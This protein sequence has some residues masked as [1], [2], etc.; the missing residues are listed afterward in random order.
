MANRLANIQV[1]IVDDERLML[2][3]V[4]EVL[5]KL[6][7]Q[8]ITVAGSGREAIQQI[9]RNH[10]DFIITDWRMGDMDGIDILHFVRESPQSPYL[11]IPV[12]LLTGNTEAKN[13]IEARDAGVT[14]YIIKPFSA[15]QLT[16]RIKSI[17]ELPRSFVEAPTYHGPDRRWHDVVPPDGIDRRNK[18]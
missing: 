12:I 6:G 16:K 14:E 18:A 10:F 17:I 3:L 15:K 13:V 1:L 5:R 7:F 8:R 4:N 2:E 11:R 9:M